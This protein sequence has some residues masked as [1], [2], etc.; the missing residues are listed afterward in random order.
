MTRGNPRLSSAAEPMR[1]AYWVPAV[2]TG[3]LAS[4][5]EQRF[6]WDLDYNVELAEIAEAA[7][8]E[9]G[10]TATRF[11]ST[12]LDEGQHEAVALSQFILARTRRIKIISAVL[13]GLWHPAVMAKIGATSDVLSGG[14]F[15]I[16]IVSGWDK[17]QFAAMGQPWLDHD[18]RYR[19][20]EEF[21]EILK[22]CWTGEPF[23]HHGDHFQIDG[24]QMRPKPLQ[25]PHPPIFQGG[26]ST[27]ARRM[28]GRHSD[29]YLT[30]G[31]SPADIAPQ[32]AEV[33]AH[34]AAADR[35]VRFGVN[36][37]AI[38]HERREQ[39]L[40][41]Y[42]EIIRLADWDAVQRFAD[43][44]REAG[45]NTSDGVGNWAK[46]SLADF[47][48]GNDGFKTGLI[49]TPEHI[50]R[51]IMALKQVGVG[52]ILLGFLHF[53]EDIEFFGRRV[54]PLVRALEG[55]QPLVETEPPAPEQAKA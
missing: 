3:Y 35:T 2:S 16:N 27:A 50:A 51:R 21:I 17:A 42:D 9:Y 47:V 15:A 19:R 11:V 49:G 6:G 18:E 44:T 32:I 10:L 29:W 26:S 40:A 43:A 52:L 36:A 48:Q 4:R 25:A 24:F 7:G 14:R 45:R 53:K 34:A 37:F 1:F 5:I 39:A 31:G 13:T 20:S 8:F 30:N 55:E 12:F 28:A 22:G 38:A 54:I 33:Q 46:S 41:T 23:T